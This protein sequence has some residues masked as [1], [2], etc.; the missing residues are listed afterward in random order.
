MD[1]QVVAVIEN[2]RHLVSKGHVGAGQLPVGDADRPVVLANWDKFR[3]PPRHPKWRD[4][5]PR[6]S[7]MARQAA[8]R[9]PALTVGA[10]VLSDASHASATARTPSK[11]HVSEPACSRHAARALRDCVLTRVLGPAS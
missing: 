9:R 6:I 3:E 10:A 8:K 1:A 11:H 5:F 4:V 7:A 2:F